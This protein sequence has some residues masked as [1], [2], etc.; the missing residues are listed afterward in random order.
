V[1]LCL[2]VSSHSGDSVLRRRAQADSGEPGT[3][4]TGEPGTTTTGELG[5]ITTAE[6]GNTTTAELGNTTTTTAEPGNATTAEPGGNTTTAEPGNTTTAEPQGATTGEPGTMTTVELVAVSPPDWPYAYFV[7]R[8]NL[9]QNWCFAARDGV[10]NGANLGLLPCDFA[11]APDNQLFLLN[12]DGKIH[13]KMN[14]DQCFAVN[15]DAVHGGAHIKFLDCD[16]PV[17]YNTFA[18]SQQDYR[19]N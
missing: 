11:N 4:T 16:A 19:F 6:L 7:I 13:S 18:H 1:V 14:K 10:E 5:N 9:F 15:K 3:T 2:V 17:T 8:A 12:R